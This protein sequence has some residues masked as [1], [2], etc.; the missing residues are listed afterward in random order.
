M[1]K[2]LTDPLMER[3]KLR[4]LRL[5]NS[6]EDFSKNRSR[7]VQQKLARLCGQLSDTWNQNSI[8]ELNKELSKRSAE[9]T[10]LSSQLKSSSE[11]E[12]QTLTQKYEVLLKTRSTDL[13]LRKGRLEERKT[14]LSSKKSNLTDMS[15]ESKTMVEEL[16]NDIK[17]RS[18]NLNLKKASMLN[19][20]LMRKEAL[21]LKWSDS[22]RL[23]EGEQKAL[24]IEEKKWKLTLT[25]NSELLNELLTSKKQLSSELESKS[26]TFQEN[27][28]RK[29]EPKR[30]HLK[31]LKEQRRQLSEAFNTEQNNLLEDLKIY[32]Q[33]LR[34]ELRQKEAKLKNDIATLE[35]QLLQHCKEIISMELESIPKEFQN[36]F[37]S[38]DDYSISL[39]NNA[40][41]TGLDELTRALNK[42]VISLGVTL[43]DFLQAMDKMDKNDD[44]PSIN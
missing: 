20:W 31:K 2:P 33:E 16:T 3:L 1:N 14:R 19:N 25:E 27:L 29:S 11:T 13:S 4:Y 21:Q 17:K 39:R 32:E 36:Y 22:F 9:L 18:E 26:Q 12:I 5:I 23:E 37:I 44:T 40:L 24:S 28:N 34:V 10:Q 8:E 7:A 43:D 30:A 42:K 38:E 15:V 41:T 6:N 35:K